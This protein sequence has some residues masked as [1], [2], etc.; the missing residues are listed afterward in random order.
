MM[1]FDAPVDTAYLRQT[2]RAV[3]ELACHVKNSITSMG[4]QFPGSRGPG[5]VI[6]S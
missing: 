2:Q 6:Y 1:V 4:Y 3:A 5:A